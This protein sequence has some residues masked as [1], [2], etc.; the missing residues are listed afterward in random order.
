MQLN[1]ETEVGTRITRWESDTYAYHTHKQ[2]EE[3]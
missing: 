1:S 3:A 2:A